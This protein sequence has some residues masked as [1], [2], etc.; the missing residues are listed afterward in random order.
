MW[1]LL[2]IGL[3]G[4]LL[5]MLIFKSHKSTSMNLLPL[6]IGA[7]A[8]GIVS[9]ILRPLQLRSAYKRWSAEH[10]GKTIFIEIDGDTLVSGQE[11][12]SEGRFY[13][14]SVCNC[15]ED[16]N[17]LLLFLNKKKFLYLPKTL[18]PAACI[19]EVRAWLTLPGA[20]TSC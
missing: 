15:A 19:D 14:A 5:L 13:R 10:E 1:G 2:A 7:M 20:P 9:P 17:V 18:L 8:G 4:A 12:R 3:L 6:A 16:E 11:G